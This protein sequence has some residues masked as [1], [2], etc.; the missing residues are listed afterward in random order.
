[1]NEDH[2]HYKDIVE[3]QK[4]V[5]IKDKI[6]K[7]ESLKTT[8]ERAVPYWDNNIVPCIKTGKR[9]LVVCHGTTLRG[10]VKYLSSKYCTI[11]WKKCIQNY[12]IQQL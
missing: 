6:P 5:D 4:F 2:K 8:M 9:V 12:L 3:N 7:V 10:L 11:Y 1:M